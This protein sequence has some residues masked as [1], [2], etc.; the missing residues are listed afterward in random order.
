MVATMMKTKV[1]WILVLIG[2]F[3]AHVLAQQA[4]PGGSTKKVASN[5]LSLRQFRQ[6]FLNQRI[7]IL[8]GSMIP[9]P[10]AFLRKLRNEKDADEGGSLGGWQPMK[11][12][13][14]GSFKDD[15]DKGAFISYK[16]KDQTPKVIDIRENAVLE[17]AKEG[18]KNA[19][20]ETVTDNDIVNPSVR[21]IVQFDDGQLAEYSS[22]VSLIV[23]QQS[24]S[25][26]HWDMEFMLASVRDAHAE[27][28][29][30]NLQSTIGQKV[31]AVH[32]SL[33][34]AA[35]ITPEDLLDLGK[36][37]TKRLDD[38]M[39]LSPMTIVAANYN[40][41]Y[42]FV[43]WK[44]RLDDGREI[45]SAARYQD[46]L[47]ETGNAPSFLRRATGTLL[48]N[49]PPS[50]TAQEISA[51]SGRKI[52]RG[53]SRQALFYSWGTGRENDYGKGGKQM[54]Y[55]NQFVYLDTNGRITDWQTVH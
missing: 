31:Y 23:D 44:L 37:E 54:V 12:G 42:D 6:M 15:F 14:D 13:P 10:R 2:I 22:I 47:G 8:K 39:L 27:I 53:M 33:L 52:F 21:I 5:E 48:L 3:A 34:F 19:L 29:K 51:I 50:L 24:Y 32:D 41:R 45:I 43:V 25:P 28:M 1:S 18:Q 49:V 38:V 40:D 11:Q 16:Y 20:G 7:L 4:R 17:Q 55:G 26:D 30:R 46:D 9:D 36:R 35:D